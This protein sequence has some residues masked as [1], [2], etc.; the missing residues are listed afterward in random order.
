M[1]PFEAY[2]VAMPMGQ[3]DPVVQGRAGQQTE[4]RGLDGDPAGSHQIPWRW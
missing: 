4:E 3:P 1:I 2:G